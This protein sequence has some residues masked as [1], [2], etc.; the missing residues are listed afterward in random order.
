MRLLNVNSLTFKEFFDHDIPEYGI[1]SH[2]WGEEEIAYKDFLKG[3]KK[4][5]A[6]YKKVIEFCQFVRSR[7]IFDLGA[8]PNRKRRDPEQHDRDNRIPVSP[9]VGDSLDWIWVD[10]VCINKDSSQEL[11]EA[12]NSMFNWYAGAEECYVYMKDVPPVSS[13]PSDVFWRAFDSSEWFSRGWTLQELLAPATVVFCDQV[14]EVFG[15]LQTQSGAKQYT[16]LAPFSNCLRF[17]LNGRVSQLTGVQR[18][19][20]DGVEPIESASIAR[21][22]SWAAPRQTTRAEDEAYCLLGL[23]GVNMPLL[24]GEGRKAFLRLQEE[25][26]R[27]SEDQSIFAWYDSRP[28]EERLGLLSPSVQ[29]FEKCGDVILK[30]GERLL[31]PYTITNLGLRLHSQAVQVNIDKTDA[32]CSLYLIRLNCWGQHRAMGQVTDIELAI[33]ACNHRS[34][35]RYCR[36]RLNDLHR[37]KPRAGL[38]FPILPAALATIW[39]TRTKSGDWEFYIKLYSQSI[40]GANHGWDECKACRAWEW[41]IIGHLSAP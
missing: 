20:L 35:T 11:S 24:Y 7:K 22:L 37:N 36:S 16:E 34:P 38:L 13:A 17:E 32:D 9:L 19:Y 40:K 39:T 30:R 31:H 33:L 3:K 14:W 15:H 27:R 1:L 2:R 12:I 28:D 5:H 25:I 29:L 26:L 41:S 18:E 10:T 23:F 21:R 4:D 6:G 8:W